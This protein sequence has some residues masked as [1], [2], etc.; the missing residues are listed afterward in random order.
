MLSTYSF[1]RP[2]AENSDDR[3]KTKGGDSVDDFWHGQAESLARAAFERAEHFRYE[4]EWLRR[5]HGR[6][7]NENRRLAHKL[8]Q[9]LMQFPDF[10]RLTGHFSFMLV[11]MGFALN[12]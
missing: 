10:H 2:L 6:L 1:T 3:S 8:D 11:P 9:V 12:H 7:V 5:Q 4:V